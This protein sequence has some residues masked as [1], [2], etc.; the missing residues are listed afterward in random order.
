MSKQVKAASTADVLPQSGSKV[1]DVDTIKSEAPV[2]GEDMVDVSKIDA[3][4][5]SNDV[6][7]GGRVRIER[8][9]PGDT[10]WQYIMK[11][12]VEDFDMDRIKAVYGGGDY[13]C[14]TF[15]SNGQMYKPFRFSVDYRM[16]GTLDEVSIK[17]AAPDN[18]R[19]DQ[20]NERALVIM[21]QAL[22]QKS[23]GNNENSMIAMFGLMAQMQAENQKTMATIMAA[24]IG[25][26]P[27][28]PDPMVMELIKIQAA[29]PVQD[30]SSRMA[31]LKE[32]MVLVR[33][34]NGNPPKEEKPE[35]S[36]LEKVVNAV[37]PLLE[38]LVASR[39][40]Q[41]LPARPVPAVPA[42]APVSRPTQ[43]S[44]QA[45][46]E[47]KAREMANMVLDQ[48]MAAAERNSDPQLVADALCDALDDQALVNLGQVLTD[49]AWKVKLFDNDERLANHEQWFEE[50]RQ[51]IIQ[52]ANNVGKPGATGPTDQVPATGGQ[53][54]PG[55]N[56]D[57]A[58]K[59]A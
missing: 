8:R 13:S 29:K 41:Q 25:G 26:R 22:A 52:Y 56:P 12:P 20:N 15:R 18:Q 57:H 33:E 37:G 45:A 32:L 16:K 1:I 19:G 50:L 10:Q 14:Q 7:A 27:T 39:T 9:G 38:K 42:P 4:L 59:T 34:L 23:A 31:E 51:L 30:S 35:P 48:I 11:I 28:G 47:A 3:I 55:F 24:A 58:G 17:L 54:G 40:I 44:A 43:D 5:N 36:A 53:D 2:A 21:Q 6:K 46:R 49:D